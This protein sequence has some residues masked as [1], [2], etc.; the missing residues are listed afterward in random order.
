MQ[1]AARSNSARS[2]L[3]AGVALVGAGAIAVSPVA[4]PLPDVHVPAVSTASVSL[5]AAVD[6]FEAYVQLITNTVNNVGTLISTEIADPFPIL[7]Q[8][9]A[10]Q[11]TSGQG[12]FAGLQS[13][14]EALGQQLDP[15]NPY[16]I[17]AQLQQAVT[18]LLAGDI[19][20]AVST[21]W[22]AL[23]SPVLYAGL[24]L[25]EPITNAIKQPVQNLLNVINDPTAVLIP[26]LGAL[27]TV[28]PAVLVSGN[29]GQN[30]VD[31]I[32][33]GDPLGFVNAVLAGPGQIADAFLNGAEAAGG[34]GL[35]GPS[36]GLLSALRQ[37]RDAIANDIKPPAALTAAVA[38][39]SAAPKA[40]TKVV[41]LDVAPAPAE[42]TTT[43]PTESTPPGSAAAGSAATDS[44]TATPAGDGA[45]TTSGDKAA[46]TAKP[47]RANR[48]KQTQDGVKGAVKSI[49]DGLKKAGEGLSGKKTAS[50]SGGQSNSTGAGEGGNSSGGS[51]SHDAA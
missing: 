21:A 22:S 32:K 19:N 40:P 4:P 10:N 11:I 41:T 9:V 34:G 45:K 37:A 33:A 28:F 20:G 46:S 38:Q 44:P 31:A 7:Q 18:Q 49:T 15:S 6:P 2:Y 3:A 35:L 17:P 8:V 23:L 5:S 29:V 14:G 30:M 51:G 26:V 1:I 48:L 13:A 27:N 25:L 39:L 50:K 16:G 42:Q 24:P 47:T 36:L 43:A 12:I